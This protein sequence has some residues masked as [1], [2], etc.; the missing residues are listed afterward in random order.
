MCFWVVMVCGL[1]V[2]CLFGL[3]KVSKI[4]GFSIFVK[5]LTWTNDRYNYGNLMCIEVKRE[6]KDA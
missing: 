4:V 3:F 5:L 1:V 6:C 2:S